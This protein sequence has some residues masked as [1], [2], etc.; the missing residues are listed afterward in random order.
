MKKVLGTGGR[1]TTYRATLLRPKGKREV[2]AVKV[3]R[4]ERKKSVLREAKTLMQLN[5]AGGAPKLIGLTVMEGKTSLVMEKLNG[6]AMNKFVHRCES[7]LH[8]MRMT[9]KIDDALR[10][11]HQAGYAHRNIKFKNIIFDITN[12]DTVHLIGVGH[13]AKITDFVQE[14]DFKAYDR[15]LERIYF[16]S[17]RKR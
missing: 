14:K 17:V 3:P 7:L 13:S 15:L 10:S 12:D 2:V 16:T 6:M 4:H 11:I 8:F 9:D 5:G 1:S